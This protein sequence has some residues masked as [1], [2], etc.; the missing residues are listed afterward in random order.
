MALTLFS[1]EYIGALGVGDGS[2]R[3]ALVLGALGPEFRTQQSC[4][5]QVFQKTPMNP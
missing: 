5:W 2:V 3:K 1:N 4:K